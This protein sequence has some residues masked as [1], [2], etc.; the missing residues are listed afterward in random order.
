MLSRVADSLYWLGRYLERDDFV[1]RQLDVH[2][3]V[4]P[5]QALEAAGR[6]RNRLI[7][8]LVSESY[9]A[10][11]VQSDYDL[12]QLLTFDADNPN[13]IAVCTAAARENARQVRE[14]IN[15]QMWEQLNQLY[16]AVQEA[17]LAQLWPGQPH[18]FYHGINQDVYRFQGI[19]DSRM[20]RDQG[21][22]FIQLGRYL[23]RAIATAEVLD[24][25]F[26]DLYRGGALRAVVADQ[27]SYLEWVGL[28][29]GCAA[30]EAYTRVYT[31]E[32]EPRHIAEFLLLNPEFPYS[33]HF[34]ID[35]LQ[36]SL[37]AIGALTETGKT[38]RVQRLVGRLRAAVDYGQID[39]IMDA[40]LGGY[41][42][43]IRRK[44]GEIHA[45]IYQ[46]YISYPIEEK[47]AA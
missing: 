11:R 43:D 37:S 33:V 12:A 41:L 18:R 5:E 44:C 7:A 17:S 39:E 22:H 21:W 42:F 35:V 4:A 24:V 47:L 25:E 9:P 23:E 15:S 13:A 40:G 31:L 36:A 10:E 34:A 1:A 32:V 30:Y 26:R 29:R 3:T 45:A 14:Q 20:S 6:R 28:L 19:T 8:C 38:A 2:L 27:Q 46:T 16:L